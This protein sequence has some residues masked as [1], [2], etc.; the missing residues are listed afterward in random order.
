[1]TSG[2]ARPARALGALL[3][4]LAANALACRAGDAPA[5]PPDGNVVRSFFALG[6]TGV[7]QILPDL[8]SRQ[9]AVAHGLESEDRRA[10][11]DA[12]VLLGD[13]FYEEGLREERLVSQLRQNLVEPYC[14]FLAFGAPRSAEVEDACRVPAAE[15]RAVPFL[16]VL[17]NHDYKSAES[18]GLQQETVPRFVA[19]WRVPGALAEAFTLGEGVDLVLVDS[20]RLVNG[21]GGSGPA[22]AAPVRAALARTRGPFRIVAAHHPMAMANGQDHEPEGAEMRYREAMRRVIAESG[23]PV[24]LFLSGHVHNLQ[25]LEMSAPAPPLHVVSGGGGRPRPV[26]FDTP[27]RRFGLATTGFARIDLVRRD[28]A[29]RLVASLFETAQRPLYGNPPPALRARFSVDAQGALKDEGPA[30]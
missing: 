25:V 26:R 9:L 28:G 23:V 1:V 12:I 2:T 8:L 10:P 15:R 27:E 11:V 18:P 7:P 24:Q 6:D 30:R 5:P 21:A 17:G 22:D 19:N 13:N 29:D 16:A 20:E 3:L 4:A 14:R